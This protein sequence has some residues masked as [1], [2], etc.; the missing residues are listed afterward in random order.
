VL[1]FVKV[2]FEKIQETQKAHSED[3]AELKGDIGQ[4]LRDNREEHIKLF[5]G[6]KACENW[7][8][9]ANGEKVGSQLTYGRL[10]AIMTVVAVSVSGLWYAISILAHKW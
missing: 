6:L 5:E 2:L 10:I 4:A 8:S 9:T 3:L 1:D 7:Q